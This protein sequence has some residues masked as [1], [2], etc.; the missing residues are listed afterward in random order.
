MRHRST[1]ADPGPYRAVDTLRDFRECHG[2]DRLGHAIVRACRPDPRRRPVVRCHHSPVRAAIRERR[3]LL[4]PRVRGLNMA[5]IW[6]Y[7][8]NRVPAVSHRLDC[9]GHPG[10]RPDRRS[11]ETVR[12]GCSRQCTRLHRHPVRR[13]RQR[14]PPEAGVL[15]ADRVSPQSPV[16]GPYYAAIRAGSRLPTTD[17]YAGLADKVEGRV[18]PSDNHP[19]SSGQSVNAT[20]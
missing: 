3:P 6:S 10:R 18:I 2:G 5:S 16:G 12:A 4:A 13:L 17:D 19:R 15:A 11:G 1:S 7:D 8:R 9:G 14:Q 20:G